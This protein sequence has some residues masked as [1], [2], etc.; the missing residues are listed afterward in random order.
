[1]YKESL[2]ACFLPFSPHNFFQYQKYMLSCK[3][4]SAWKSRSAP[5]QE[6]QEQRRW[7]REHLYSD[8][9]LVFMPIQLKT[10]E[11]AGLK[12]THCWPTSLGN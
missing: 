3:L 8:S 5:S 6:L 7:K 4:W 2:Q 1:M 10:Y 11:I 9:L 12:N